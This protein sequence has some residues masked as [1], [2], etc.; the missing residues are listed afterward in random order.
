MFFVFFAVLLYLAEETQLLLK[1]TTCHVQTTFFLIKV[2]EKHLRLK[3]QNDFF[4]K[5]FLLRN[6]ATYITIYQ[7]VLCRYKEFVYTLPITH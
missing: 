3:K 2:S 1:K 5:Y 4:G 7:L 6:V